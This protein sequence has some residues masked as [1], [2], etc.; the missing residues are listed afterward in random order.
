MNIPLARK[1]IRLFSCDLVPQSVNK[2]NRRSWL[3]SVE[4]LGDRWLLAK[5]MRRGVA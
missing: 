4:M 3:R 1:A 5:P 2:Y